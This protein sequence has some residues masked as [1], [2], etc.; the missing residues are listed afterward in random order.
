MWRGILL[1]G[2]VMGIVTLLTIDIFLPGG[3][4][5]G[6]HSF[7]EAQ[8]AGFTTLVLPSCSTR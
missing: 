8:T 7:R 2:A 1:V 3:L 6:T 4:V 5:E